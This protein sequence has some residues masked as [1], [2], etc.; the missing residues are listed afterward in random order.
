M[1]DKENTTKQPLNIKKIAKIII[2]LN[3]D[4]DEILKDLQ[5]EMGDEKI[6]D[7]IDGIL[8][9]LYNQIKEC[10]ISYSDSYAIFK[11]YREDE[12]DDENDDEKKKRRK[13]FRKNLDLLISATLEE[14]AK[15]ESAK[16]KLAKKAKAEKVFKLLDYINLEF[17]I[18]EASEKAKK[19]QE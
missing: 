18:S 5:N 9:K 2:K 4:Q 12:D 19:A 1:S 11:K 7:G 10:N 3:K 13:N 6:V 14:S 8:E 17:S 16:E 15:E